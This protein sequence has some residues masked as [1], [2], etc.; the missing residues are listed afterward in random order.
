MSNLYML[1]DLKSQRA[2]DDGDDLSDLDFMN[3]V[4]PHKTRPIVIDGNIIIDGVRRFMKAQELGWDYI[5]GVNPATVDEAVEALAANHKK[6]LTRWVQVADIV[7]YLR[8]LNKPRERLMRRKLV[9]PQ[10][11][12]RDL[13]TKALGGLNSSQ[14][15]KVCLVLADPVVGPG[16]RAGITSPATAYATLMKQEKR[17]G[18]IENAEEQAEIYGNALR[19]LRMVNE[20]LR[21]LGTIQLEPNKALEI[22]RNFNSARNS[23]NALLRRLEEA[24][25]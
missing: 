22:R 25:K 12:I 5:V 13:M 4:G 21:K 19:Q 2:L 16:V 6:P 7:L 10:P 3:K 8:K 18:T 1:R 11:P 9:G 20:S 23:L 17:R 14:F 24:F 15:E